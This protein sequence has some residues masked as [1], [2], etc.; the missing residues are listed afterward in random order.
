VACLGNALYTIIII[1][2]SG[3]LTPPHGLAAG[4]IWPL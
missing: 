2:Y 3:S 4:I 1:D